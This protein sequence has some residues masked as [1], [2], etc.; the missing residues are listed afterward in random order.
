MSFNAREIARWLGK[1][2]ELYRFTRQDLNWRYANG[3]QTITVGA[4]TFEPL[5]ITRETIKESYERQK[6]NL[7]ITIPIGAEVAENWQP[8]PPGDAVTVTLMA[9]HR[10][11]AELIVQWTGRVVQPRYTDT[12]LELTCSPGTGSR[13]P[14]GM[15]LRFQRSCPLVLYSQGVGMCNLSPAA[16]AAPAVLASAAGNI[17]SAGAWAAL[18]AG[19]LAGG[20][21][22]WTSDNGLVQRRSITGHFGAE[23]HL[24]YGA[25]DLEAGLAVTAYHG[26]AHNFADC[27]S[28]GNGDNYGGC[29][30][31]PQKNPFSGN[32]IWW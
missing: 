8:F 28:K 5:A 15:Q 29:S 7:K 31:L 12:T 9:M 23:L 32:P 6:R 21:M 11:D 26:C 10:G 25:S 18:P 14:R 24:D 30:N 4:E 22:E 16:F 2:V 13:R 17:V 20:F 27:D 1:P 3:D 19:R